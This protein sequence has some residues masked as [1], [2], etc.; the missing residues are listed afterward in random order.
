[1]V[2][3]EKKSFASKR[4]EIRNIELANETRWYRRVLMKL[5]V[6]WRARLLIRSLVVVLALATMIWL[7]HAVYKVFMW[8]L[9]N[10]EHTSNLPISESQLLTWLRLE[11]NASMVSLNTDDLEHRLN[12]LPQVKS[13]FV[14]LRFPGTLHVN[15]QMRVP[16]ASL[17]CPNMHDANGNPISNLLVDESGVPFPIDSNVYV[18]KPGVLAHVVLSDKRH[19]GI[20]Y[21]TPLPEAVPAVKILLELATVPASVVP[22]VAMIDMCQPWEYRVTFQ[23][24]SMNVS[25]PKIDAHANV[26]KLVQIVLH[27]QSQGK[28]VETI[29]LIPQIN[30]PVRYKKP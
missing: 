7:C 3:D 20:S 23:G 16:V 21:G 13:A 5:T 24:S 9:V 29:N 11:D 15:L 26:D 10:V 12:E 18:F 4:P 19:G 28:M 17:E 27:A 25:F 2:Q 14:S 8:T 30:I 22:P 6:Y 1:M